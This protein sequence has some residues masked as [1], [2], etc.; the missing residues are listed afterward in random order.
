MICFKYA[1]IFGWSGMGWGLGSGQDRLLISIFFWF[2]KLS[3]FIQVKKVEIL[4]VFGS[5]QE[6]LVPF[7]FKEKTVLF[8]L[9]SLLSRNEK[10]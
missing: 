10:S 3:I 7:I 4:K 9:I 6:A 2:I 1:N 8:S 5:D